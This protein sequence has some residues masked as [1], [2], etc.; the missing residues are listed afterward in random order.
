LMFNESTLCRAIFSYVIYY[1]HHRP[2]RSIGQ[3]GPCAAGRAADRLPGM[4]QKV[5]AEPVLGGLHNI[6]SHAS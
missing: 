4:Q 6:Y 1:N 5:I 3:R 2:H